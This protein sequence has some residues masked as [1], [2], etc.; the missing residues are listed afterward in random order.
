MI[1]NDETIINIAELARLEL[2]LE[3]IEWFK[4]DMTNILNHFDKLSEIN[5]DSVSPVSQITWLLNI[6]RNDEINSF[7]P[8]KELISEAPSSSDNWS[9][10]VKNV[11]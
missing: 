9:I 1:I 6:T 11:L 4:N 8:N 7:K 5:T 10:L 2:S 3:E